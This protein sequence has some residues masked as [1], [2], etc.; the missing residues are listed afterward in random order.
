MPVTPIFCVEP[1]ET[2]TTWVEPIAMELVR[3]ILL[4]GACGDPARCEGASQG[5]RSK[6]RRFL[7]SDGTTLMMNPLD[8]LLRRLA[9]Q[10]APRVSDQLRAKLVGLLE[11]HVND[12]LLPE[13][14]RR[15]EAIFSDQPN[16]ASM[17]STQYVWQAG[18]PLGPV[19][20]S[21]R[22][23]PEALRCCE[24]LPQEEELASVLALRSSFRMGDYPD[25][26]MNDVVRAFRLIRGAK[27]YV[28]IGIFDRG[29]LAY[30]STL[31]S[32]DAVIVGVDIRDDPAQDEKLRSFLKPSQTYLP[33]IGDSRLPS[34]FASVKEALQGRRVD[35]VFIDGNH[36]AHS[37]LCDYT[38]S[39]AL[40]RDDGVIL[41]HDSVWE[42]DA[43]DKGVADTLAE[44]NAVDP[45]Y[46]ID[47]INPPWRFMR[48]LWKGELWGVVGVV[49]ASEQRWRQV[50]MLSDQA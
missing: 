26:W 1:L 24:A 28:E 11:R 48:P 2:V 23:V 40:V 10:V 35:A 42:G 18:G 5:Y 49:L 29:N 3:R 17:E 9:V 32:E 38:N 36:T 30:A 33:I 39:E 4:P 45:V 41:F 6:K 14:Q 7:G 16:T 13:V 46:L 19:P 43:H 20:R 44:I 8:S 22:V 12:T 21:F 15:A 37:V 34:T 27:T 31:L 25:P 47:A 50:P